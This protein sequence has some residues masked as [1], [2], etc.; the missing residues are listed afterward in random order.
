MIPKIIHQI[1]FRP[2]GK[3]EEPLPGDFLKWVES[4]KTIHPNWDYVL[5]DRSLCDTFVAERF[6]ECLDLYNSFP[7][8]I[9]RIDFVRCLILS[10]L[11]GVYVDMDFECL[12]PF[13]DLVDDSVRGFFVGLHKAPPNKTVSNALIASAPQHPVMTDFISLLVKKGINSKSKTPLLVTGPT[14]LTRIV[15]KY[16]DDPSVTIFDKDYFYPFSWEKRN[17]DN[18]ITENTYA[19]HYWVSLWRKPEWD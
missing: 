4:W 17:P 10:L 9:Y 11:G 6:P 16:Q 3:E 7:K 8:N 2:E 13:D 19:R 14:V 12:K 5:W 15:R 18:K 1:W